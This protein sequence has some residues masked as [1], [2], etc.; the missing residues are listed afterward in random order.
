MWH[1][2]DDDLGA[3][4]NGADQAVRAEHGGQPLRARHDRGVALGPAEDRRDEQAPVPGEVAAR[5]L[6]APSG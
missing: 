5:M 3:G 1:A 2:I 4:F 6:D